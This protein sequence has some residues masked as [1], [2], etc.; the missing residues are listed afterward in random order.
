MFCTKD[1][2]RFFAKFTGKRLCQSLFLNKVADLRLQIYSKRDSGTGVF[3]QMLQNF[4]EQLFYGTPLGGY[5][6]M[7][8][9]LFTLR[10]IDGFFI[11]KYLARLMTLLMFIF[12]T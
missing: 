2:L 6:R 5:F 8:P 1:D 11:N 4:Q 3:L 7:A 9:I 10:G 12:K